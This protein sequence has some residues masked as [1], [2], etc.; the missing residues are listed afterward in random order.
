MIQHP[1]EFDGNEVL[2][3]CDTK[4]STEDALLVANAAKKY[5]QCNQSPFLQPPLLPTLGYLPYAHS[6]A[7]LNGSFQPPPE[8]PYFA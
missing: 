6:E 1:T 7:I 5:M 4:T 3:T 8:T 2:H